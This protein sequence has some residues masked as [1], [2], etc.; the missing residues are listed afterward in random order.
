MSLQIVYTSCES[1]LEITFSNATY[2][3]AQVAAASHRQH[4]LSNRHTHTHTHIHTHTQIYTHTHTYTHTDRS[5]HTH[6]HTHTHTRARIYTTTHTHTHTHTHA[7]TRTHTHSHTHA[8]TQ[9]QIEG[10]IV[11]AWK[12]S[13][14]SEDEPGQ[15]I[16]FSSADAQGL[17]HSPMQW[18][19]AEVL[20]HVLHRTSYIS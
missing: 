7:H 16:L 15:R 6:T 12:N 20:S 8:H 3:L 1:E 2:S 11:V 13:L 9:L 18:T 5:A 10:R 4:S 14:S 19:P 17:A